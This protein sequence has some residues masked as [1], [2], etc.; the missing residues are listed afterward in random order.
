MLIHRAT[1]TARLNHLINELPV[2]RR[3]DPSDYRVECWQGR[4]QELVDAIAQLH[5]DSKLRIT[6]EDSTFW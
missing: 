6:R 3:L 2:I 1:L 5:D 4:R